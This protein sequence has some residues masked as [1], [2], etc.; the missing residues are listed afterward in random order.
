MD[1]ARIHP[2]TSHGTKTRG[3]KMGEICC[4]KKLLLELKPPMLEVEVVTNPEPCSRWYVNLLVFGRT[5]LILCCEQTTLAAVILAKSDLKKP[6]ATGLSQ[7]LQSRAAAL[8]AR[9]GRADLKVP[10]QFGVVYQYNRQMLG[11]MKDMTFSLET[12]WHEGEDLASIEDH[13]LE[14]LHSRDRAY[15]R[16]R[17]AL[18]AL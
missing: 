12:R 3:A 17:A 8:L 7:A 9:V 5:K 2:Q 6:Y 10:E 15:Q 16:P 11:Y 1:P 13:L 4:T 14:V 18:M